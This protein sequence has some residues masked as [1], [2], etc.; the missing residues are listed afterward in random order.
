MNRL[1]IIDIKYNAHIYCKA[2][3]VVLM[4]SLK[5]S[6]VFL[7]IIITFST[8]CSIFFQLHMIPDYVSIV[9]RVTR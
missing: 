3:V 9:Y 8:C 5:T 6:P 1:N 2:C 7:T 4:Q